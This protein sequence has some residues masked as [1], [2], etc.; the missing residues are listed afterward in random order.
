VIG[1]GTHI[2]HNA[3]YL[4]AVLTNLSDG[5]LKRLSLDVGKHYVHASL[6]EAMGHS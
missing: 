1:I 3:L 2:A 6:G 5:Q 4:R